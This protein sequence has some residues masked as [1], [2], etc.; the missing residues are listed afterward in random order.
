MGIRCRRGI[1]LFR[2]GSTPICSSS[3]GCIP[4]TATISGPGWL[5]CFS[6]LTAFHKKNVSVSR[7]LH[8]LIPLLNPL[9][10]TLSAFS[11]QRR[12]PVSGRALAATRLGASIRPGT[13]GN[14]VNKSLKS[15]VLGYTLSVLRLLSISSLRTLTHGRHLPIASHTRSQLHIAQSS[16][17]HSQSI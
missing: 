4:K 16:A 6:L 5:S 15:A 8:Y 17:F 12:R 10:Y 13:H 1:E 9:S 2:S 3:R 7:L 14:G 11:F